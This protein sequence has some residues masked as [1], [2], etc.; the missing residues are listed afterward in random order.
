MKTK[1][2]LIREEMKEAIKQCNNKQIHFFKRMYSNDKMDADINDIIDSMEI[3][4]LSIAYNQ[5]F[6]TIHNGW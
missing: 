6:R 2:Q 4:K 3:N 1:D 5:I